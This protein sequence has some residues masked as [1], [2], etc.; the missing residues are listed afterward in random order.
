MYFSSVHLWTQI[1][2]EVEQTFYLGKKS[3]VDFF[4]LH[5]FMKKCKFIFTEKM[6]KTSSNSKPGPSKRKNPFIDDEAV[7]ERKT[8]KSKKSGNKSYESDDSELE[9]M[10]PS[11][12]SESDYEEEIV[13]KKKKA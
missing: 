11:D 5:F 12:E 13:N 2:E 8:S 9:F 7:A 3:I 1:S 4:I 6:P 10:S